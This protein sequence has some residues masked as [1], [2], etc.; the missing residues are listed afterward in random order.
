MPTLRALTP[1]LLFAFVISQ[2]AHAQSW[3]PK[4]KGA[5][6]GTVTLKTND[7]LTIPE[8]VA[9]LRMKDGTA[10]FVVAKTAPTVDLAFHRNLGTNAVSRRLWS[11]WGDIGLAKDGRVYCG[12][13][14]HGNAVGGDA[15]CFHV[16]ERGFKEGWGNG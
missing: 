12:I 13:G 8:S 5:T 3:P 16:L 4:L 14:D 6:N 7:F 2:E 9:A 11:S 10:P 1:I 15:R